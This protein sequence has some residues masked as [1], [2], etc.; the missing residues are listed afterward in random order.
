MNRCICG[1]PIHLEDSFVLDCKHDLCQDCSRVP[2]ISTQCPACRIQRALESVPL[3]S[4]ALVRHIEDVYKKH[5]ELVMEKQQALRGERKLFDALKRVASARCD[6]GNVFEGL[7]LSQRSQEGVF[8]P[9]NSTPVAKDLFGSFVQDASSPWKRRRTE[10][11]GFGGSEPSA[12]D[13]VAYIQLS[14]ERRQQDLSA[15]LDQ[16]K[17]AHAQTYSQ[18]QSLCSERE[19]KIRALE[20]R[21]RAAEGEASFHKSNIDSLGAS[22]AKHSQ[23]G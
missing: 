16:M 19:D 8:K 11:G 15:S 3:D 1:C 21:C 6:A 13:L 2:S 23:T 22:S 18:L 4:A 7:Q 17:E 14:H 9:E 20:E 5:K 12:N 10:S